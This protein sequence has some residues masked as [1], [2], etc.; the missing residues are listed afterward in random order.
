VKVRCHSTEAA[1]RTV[2]ERFMFI[3]T[4]LTEKADEGI[5]DS[6]DSWRERQQ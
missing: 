6:E 4:T 3:E 2:F 1:E 5:I